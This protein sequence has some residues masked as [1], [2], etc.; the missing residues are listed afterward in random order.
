MNNNKKPFT[1]VTLEDL[2]GLRGLGASSILVYM[3]LRIYGGKDS[4]AWPSQDRI[5]SDLGMPI[6]TVRK[7][8]AAL[9]SKGLIKANRNARTKS[10]TY[11][12]V[13]VHISN[14]VCQDKSDDTKSD[15]STYQIRY[16]DIPN[17]I[18]ADTKSDI[19]IDKVKDKENIQLIDKAHNVP[20]QIHST[21]NKKRE[22]ND[23]LE[24]DELDLLFVELWTKHSTTHGMTAKGGNP[25]QGWRQVKARVGIHQA[26]RG[27]KTLDLKMSA[28]GRPWQSFA[29]GRWILKLEAW[30]KREDDKPI[31]RR[32]SKYLAGSIEVDRRDLNR[33]R[34]ETRKAEEANERAQAIA[35]QPTTAARGLWR[36]FRLNNQEW[37]DLV[38][39]VQKW[40]RTFLTEELRAEIEADDLLEDFALIINL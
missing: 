6:P 38:D 18:F 34:Q 16:P 9:R 33:H 26:K 5:A 19:Q 31:D 2:A 12:I 23:S 20:K 35:L 15:I 8:F 7:A 1:Q 29:G 24:M 36:E 13:D 28:S 11:Q 4:T 17:Q 10:T 30:I 40:K 37:C 14:M 25:I 27:L 39:A 32:E 3:A 21:D 22:S